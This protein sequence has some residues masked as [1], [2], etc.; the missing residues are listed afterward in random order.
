MLRN[1]AILFEQGCTVRVRGSALSIDS[2]RPGLLTS[3][4]WP[5]LRSSHDSGSAG[6]DHFTPATYAG[7]PW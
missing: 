3:R 5:E 6:A 4:T 1:E 2:F 7:G